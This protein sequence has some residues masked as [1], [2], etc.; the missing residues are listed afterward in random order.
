MQPA[1][2]MPAVY[3][4]DQSSENTAAKEPGAAA[5]HRL[6]EAL[7][8][9]LAQAQHTWHLKADRGVISSG[10]PALDN[11]LPEGGFLQG[12]LVEWL[13]PRRGA[14]TLQLALLTAGSAAREGGAIVVLDR[15]KQFHPPA[16]VRSGVPTDRLVIVQPENESEE[17]W[18]L[19]QALRSLA[20]AA[21]IA[22]PERLDSHSYRRLQLAAEQGGG[23]G[24]L[25][26]PDSAR[27]ECSWAEVRLLVEPLARREV[28]DRSCSSGL[29]LHEPQRMTRRMRISVLRC[30]G[31]CDPSKFVEIEI[32][33]ALDR[34][35]VS[36]QLGDPTP[37]RRAAGA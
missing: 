12:T 2:E 10:C 17:L 22:W 36:A 35:R 6:L 33:D 7:R 18:A 16:A 25:L 11:L 5:R 28:V 8:H 37:S 1:R 19:D 9:Q 24:L 29:L 27:G 26:R 31:S 15:A 21:T 30:R 34:V 32:D 14:G 20:A 3:P 23:L 13:T 4:I